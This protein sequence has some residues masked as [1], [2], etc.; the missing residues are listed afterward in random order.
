MIKG[1]L[2]R[3]RGGRTRNKQE[4]TGIVQAGSDED[5]GSADGR[6]GTARR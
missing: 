6:E 1:R 4:P 3:G 5:C 2:R